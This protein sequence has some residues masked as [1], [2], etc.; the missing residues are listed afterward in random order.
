MKFRF[1]AAIAVISL[2]IASQAAHAETTTVIVPTS[3]GGGLD[4]VARI[5]TSALQ[6]KSSDSYVVDNRGGANGLI[7]A[8][9]AAAARPARSLPRPAH[10]APAHAAAPGRSV[11]RAA[12]RSAAL[13]RAGSGRC[14][15]SHGRPRRCDRPSRWGGRGSG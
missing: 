2:C 5:V 14:A 4:G 8:K 1:T 12:R 9:A 7:G 15:C 3:A 11:R 13:R 6:T 10:R